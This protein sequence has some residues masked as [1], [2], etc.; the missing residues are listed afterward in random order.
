MVKSRCFTQNKIGKGRLCLYKFVFSVIGILTLP[1]CLTSHNTAPLAPS[2]PDMVDS[3]SNTHNQDIHSHRQAL[4]TPDAKSAFDLKVI[5]PSAG[6]GQAGDIVT[7]SARKHE[8][9]QKSQ[10]AIYECR[11]KDRFDRKALLAYEWD[12]SR[13]SVD[14][15]GINMSGSG[16]KGVYVQYKLTFNPDKK[17]P[18]KNCMHP[19]QWRGMI[20]TGYNEFIVRDGR[21]VVEDVKK[22]KKQAMRYV[23]RVF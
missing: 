21:V 22:L 16:D 15:D 10:E 2:P 14:V 7:A 9:Q 18:K 8:K 5:K 1:G 12:R 23:D 20:G 3:S 4:A 11:L 13:L 6:A 19:S 17:D